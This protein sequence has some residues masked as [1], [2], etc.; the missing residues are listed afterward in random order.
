V[1]RA[2]SVVMTPLTAR[3]VRSVFE[4]EVMLSEM[5]TTKLH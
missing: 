5:K 4:R 3:R 2:V 1:Q